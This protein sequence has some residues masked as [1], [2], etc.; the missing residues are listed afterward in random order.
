MEFVKSPVTP[1]IQV[2]PHIN[3]RGLLEDYGDH[4]EEVML[5]EGEE[6]AGSGGFMETVK[7]K[8]VCTIHYTRLIIFMECNAGHDWARRCDTSQVRHNAFT[9]VWLID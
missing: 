9:L 8:K 7:R 2:A 6:E 4:D 5:L 3:V 1:L